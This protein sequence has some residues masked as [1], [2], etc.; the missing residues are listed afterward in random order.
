MLIKRMARE[1]PSWGYQPIQGEL[2]KLGHRVGPQRSAA[3][4]RGHGYL[5]RRA[6]T[7]TRP[8]GSSCAPRRQ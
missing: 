8:G 5:R 6:G 2:L 7:P 1:N 4:S 3:S